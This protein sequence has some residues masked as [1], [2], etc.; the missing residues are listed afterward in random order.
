MS[1][2]TPQT[3][4]QTGQSK[5]GAA[6]I[7]IILAAFVLLILA[8]GGD[9]QGAIASLLKWLT[10]GAIDV[11]PLLASK[12]KKTNTTTTSKTSTTSTSKT[13]VKNTAKTKSKSQ[14]KISILPKGQTIGIDTLT[15]AGK[16]LEGVLGGN[17]GTTA[18]AAGGAAATG[19]GT[20]GGL[21]LVP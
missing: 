21:V 15:P 3:I 19:L 17:V 11:A 7:I 1:T 6:T 18:T 8:L 16:W 20:L 13:P 14:T 10:G 4:V 2:Q 5:S 12:N 9:V